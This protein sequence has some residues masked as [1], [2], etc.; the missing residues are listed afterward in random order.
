MFGQLMA[1]KA[2]SKF[3]DSSYPEE[4]AVFMPRP[5]ITG[6][7]TKTTLEDVVIEP[8][9][10]GPSIPEICSQIYPHGFNFFP[11]DIKKTRQFYEFI[12]VDTVSVEI[13]HIPNRNNSEKVVYTTRKVV[14]YDTS[15]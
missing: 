7:Q 1:E 8:K 11:E 6:Y 15:I 2:E 5:P 14:F 12:L 9:F 10:D 4:S 3:L 13:T